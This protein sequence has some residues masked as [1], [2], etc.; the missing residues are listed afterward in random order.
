MNKQMM[1]YTLLMEEK[2]QL[3]DLLAHQ[4][5]VLRQDFNEVKQQLAPA[6]Q[7][8]NKVSGFTKSRA[9]LS[10]LQTGIGIGADIFLGSKLLRKAG[11]LVKIVLPIA[12]RILPATLNSTKGILQKALQ[13]FRKNPDEK[14]S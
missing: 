3:E 13:L 1:N 4:K 8:L 9:P 2:Q 10:L 6:F 7:L 11:P 14:A 12:L 5:T